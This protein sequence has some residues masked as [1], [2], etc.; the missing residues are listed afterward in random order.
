LRRA[1]DETAAMMRSRNF[2]LFVRQNLGVGECYDDISVT[3]TIQ[4]KKAYW[5][6]MRLDVQ[7]HPLS[8]HLERHGLVSGLHGR[9]STTSVASY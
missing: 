2:A 9:L 8:I 5:V 4:G 3:L 7:G 1:K 6:R